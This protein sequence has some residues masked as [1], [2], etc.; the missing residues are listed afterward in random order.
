M[1]ELN[2]L[3]FPVTQSS[4]AARDVSSIVDEQR[5]LEVLKRC[6]KIILLAGQAKS[7]FW[8]EQTILY[9]EQDIR[10]KLGALPPYAVIDAPPPP[11]LSASK[12]MAVLLKDSPSFRDELQRWLRASTNPL[13]TPPQAVAG[14]A[15]G[16]L[17]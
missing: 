2:I 8:L 3:V 11:P 1:E 12:R 15:Q 9:I 10:R 16:R 13:T 4:E 17:H 7:D 5:F 14:L 6:G